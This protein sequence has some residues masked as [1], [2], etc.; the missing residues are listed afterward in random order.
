MKKTAR[1][2]FLVDMNAFFIGCEALR[3]PSLKSR[4]AAVAG[5][6]KRRSGI[7]LT[8]NYE[9]RK[10]G[11]KT[12]MTIYQAEK[13]CPEI[14]L[15]PPDRKLYE[16]KSREVME[17]FGQFTPIVEQNSIDEAWLDLTGC[18]NI[19]GKPTEIAKNIMAR[20]NNELGL[21]CS[22]G[23]SENKFL[24]K[25][26]ADLRKPQGISEI[27]LSEIKQ[28]LWPLPVGDLYGIGKQ[29]ASKLHA[30]G[31]RTIGDLA[32]IGKE[33]LRT[34]FGKY[35]GEI[36]LLA[37]GFDN[38]PVVP[39]ED[40]EM[41]SI[42]RSTT[43]PQDISDLKS[44]KDKVA[45]L[46]EEVGADLRRH[47]KKCT[48]IQITIKHADFKT[49]T[50]Q[51]TIAPTNL[52]KQIIAIA[53]ELLQKN[54]TNRAARLLGVSVSG[55]ERTLEGTQLSLFGQQDNSSSEKEEKLERTVDIIRDKYG[56]DSV[57]RAV[58]LH[59]DET[60]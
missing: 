17:L 53:N 10:Y 23:I 38:S 51:K 33:I 29:T 40:G 58:F 45:E 6:P 55:F 54:W 2:I 12:T 24:S 57:K 7:I 37:N 19:W 28:K 13:L 42:G 49:I 32:S 35:G 3:N 15:V 43:L 4:P 21:W 56:N 25:M 26:A 50:R 41:K 44:A 30:M 18:E 8:A 59:R 60:P 14:V 31:F 16:E 27:W 9:A 47:G 5:D 52:T 34:Q 48:T 20:I 39:H 22:I 1:V 36:Y 11:V 46:A